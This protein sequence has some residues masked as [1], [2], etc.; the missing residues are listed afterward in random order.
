MKDIFTP[1]AMEITRCSAV[2]RGFSSSR[3]IDTTLGFTARIMVLASFT[4]STLSVVT[5]IPRV[6]AI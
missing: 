1:A 3:T 4:T 6:L 2:R 5:T